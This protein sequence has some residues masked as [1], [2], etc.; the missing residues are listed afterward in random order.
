[1]GMPIDTPLPD[2]AVSNTT[3]GPGSDRPPGRPVT[4]T[5]TYT[6]L[7]QFIMIDPKNPAT[8]Q[9]TQTP[10]I[11]DKAFLNHLPKFPTETSLAR[12]GRSSLVIWV[13]VFSVTPMLLL[14]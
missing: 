5:G 1:M 6:T 8:I 3:G 7:P 13:L 10:P 12:I 9:T 11:I 4:G 14:I 2:R